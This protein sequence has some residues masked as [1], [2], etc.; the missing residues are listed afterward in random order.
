MEAL[1]Q[2]HMLAAKRILRY[3]K[4]TQGDGIFYPINCQVEL[5]GYTDSDWGDDVERA[6]STSGYASHIGS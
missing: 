5:V 2:S 1:R 4:G 6:K 3:V